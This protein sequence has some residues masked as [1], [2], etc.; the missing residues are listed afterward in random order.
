ML[1]SIPPADSPEIPSDLRL[2]RDLQRNT[3]LRNSLLKGA[4]EVRFQPIFDVSQRGSETAPTV[5]AY[6]ALTRGLPGTPFRSSALLF[7]TVRRESRERPAD[8]LCLSLALLGGSNLPTGRLSIN[9]HA[10]TLAND[11]GFPALV[12]ECCTRH[13]IPIERL[14][15]ELI[16]HHVETD[17]HA[18]LRRLEALRAD[19]MA[20]ALDDLGSGGSPFLRLL[21]V[22]APEFVKLDRKLLET[23]P[24]QPDRRLRRLSTFQQIAIRSGVRTVAEGIE[25]EADLN[26]VYEAGI[27]LA[28]GFYLGV[29]APA[30]RWRDSQ[31]PRV[32][33]EVPSRRPR[34]APRQPRSSVDVELHMLWRL[35]VGL[36]GHAVI[37][38]D[39]RGRVADWN[40]GAEEL[41]GRS[42]S[43]KGKPFAALFET[44][45]ESVRNAV[46]VA[47]ATG[48]W[49]HEGVLR[50]AQ[51]TRRSCVISLLPLTEPGR[52]FA[53]LLHDLTAL[54]TAEARAADRHGRLELVN[55]LLASLVA[56]TDF[57]EVMQAAVNG[58]A[59]LL[60]EVEVAFLTLG[61]EGAQVLARSAVFATSLPASSLI[62]PCLPLRPK[63]ERERAEVATAPSAAPSFL[64]LPILR[65]G[66]T[67]GML[68]LASPWPR[69]WTPDEQETLGEVGQAVTMLFDRATAERRRIELE[70]AVHESREQLSRITNAVPGAV[71]QVRRRGPDRPALLFM[72][73]GAR[74][75]FSLSQHQDPSDL[76][77]LA[78]S[79]LEEDLGQLRIA[80]EGAA[81]GRQRNITVEFR[82]KSRTGVRW[83]Q[84]NAEPEPELPDGS[85]IWNGLIV[86]ITEIKTLQSEFFRTRNEWCATV[87]SVTDMILLEDSFGRIVRCNLAA[88]RFLRLPFQA[89]IGLD[90]SAAFFGP[91]AA[92]STSLQFRSEQA[93]LQF[94]GRSEWFE[95]SNSPLHGVARRDASWV[96]VISDVTARRRF[97]EE[98][99]RLSMAIDQAGEMLLIV[100]R[101]GILQYAN[102][103]YT[104]VA[105]ASARSLVGT[106][107]FQLPMAP[108]AEA[109]RILAAV[110]D[111][112]PWHGVFST[113]G[114]D[115]G[116]HEIEATISPVRSGNGEISHF[117]C[118]ARDV[119]DARRIEAI[120]DAVNMFDQVGFV[121][122]TLRHELGN[123]VN[124]LKTALSVLH[125]NIETF[126]TQDVK[127]YLER[128]LREIHR[129]EYLLRA[130]KSFGALERPHLEGVVAADYIR[131]FT[132]L[133]REDLERRGI[134]LET[135]IGPD[136]GV[137]HVDPR[138]LNQA[139]LNLVTNAADAVAKAHPPKLRITVRRRGRRLELKVEDN[140]V[141]VAKADLPN[142]FRP[143]YTTKTNGTGLGL[144]IVRKLLSAMSSTIEV[145]SRENL[146]TAFTLSLPT[147]MERGS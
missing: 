102:P 23:R 113:P 47:A 139:L 97:E 79:I 35:C 138:A 58:L 132:G 119:T 3:E 125:Q 87:D 15:L 24:G 16:E 108:H 25:S 134:A 127:G 129:M 37:T 122:A 22:A 109:R 30:D 60:P 91:Q 116:R 19:G 28:Q 32:V 98:A 124:S 101:D 50:G 94:P 52:R 34:R 45:D 76:A 136:L 145:E 72:S 43:M 57:S 141:G 103:A 143:F 33:S 147:A 44:A 59:N 66:E 89:V 70:R 21:R 65:D 78:K 85:Q 115:C 81:R 104:S 93:T 86:D 140:G 99:R 31:R 96:H 121:F 128:S 110:L 68:R 63:E 54:R 48:C 64:D 14:V 7:E 80:F 2:D 29:P 74:Q 106:R 20:L 13:D 117:V 9:V 112:R 8:R 67:I 135:D 88:T 111:G 114:A 27:P 73:E 131:D 61:R 144:A 123:P 62:Q 17:L 10:R 51:G 130:F 5:Y 105:G 55:S 40:A 26:L 69:Q 71:Y 100:S 38:L 36:P 126:S 12:R 83:L 120:A 56:G 18:A 92:G 77:D 46:E 49:Q 84:A 41:L 142:L 82:V 4:F 137:A 1:P 90:L 107:A 11:P 75:L 6:E 146:G 133:V 118:V 39:S 42:T 53:A 95:V